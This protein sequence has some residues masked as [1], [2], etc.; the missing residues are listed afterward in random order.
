MKK[1]V[2]HDASA[3]IKGIIYQFYLAIEWCFKLKPNQSL[4]FEKDGDIAIPDEANIEVKHFIDPLTD[5][6]KN[7]WNTLANWLDPAFDHSTYSK[8]IL[9]TTQKIGSN[10]KLADWQSKSLEKRLKI[11]TDILTTKDSLNAKQKKVEP[12]LNSTKLADIIEKFEIYD[13]SDVIEDK[14]FSLVHQIGKGVPESNRT[15]LMNGLVG[16]LISPEVAVDDNWEVTEKSFATEFDLLESQFKQHTRI[17]PHKPITEDFTVTSATDSLYLQKIRD[18]EYHDEIDLA[19]SSYC[20]VLTVVSEE[21][22]Q[23]TRQKY[24][25]S[26]QSEVISAFE[27]KH[28][29]TSKKVDDVIV[30]SQI[31]YDDVL[32]SESP[33]F[34][35]YNRRPDRWFRDGVLHVNMD[36]ESL[37]LKWK[38]K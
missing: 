13:C 14:Y 36:D 30:D 37:D 6:H 29:K 24:F 23:G 20:E 17:F 11:I 2:A 34:E 3:S 4:L 38:L 7:L 19:H 15:R 8:L 32:E 25:D 12:F 27:R 9:I 10:S 18:I 21:F 35:T 31:F 22:E 28:K 33:E 5:S 1:T 16:W 26:Y